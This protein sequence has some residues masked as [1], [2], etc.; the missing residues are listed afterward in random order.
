MA[1]EPTRLRPKWDLI[2]IAKSPAQSHLT[3]VRAVQTLEDPQCQGQELEAK[4][5]LQQQEP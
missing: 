1:A 2:A 3:K 4:M 5:Q